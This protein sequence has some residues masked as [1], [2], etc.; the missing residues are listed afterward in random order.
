MTYIAPRHSCD[1]WRVLIR[2]K[3]DYCMSALAGEL[4]AHTDPRPGIVSG[5]D[6][7]SGV[8]LRARQTT[9]RLAESG[10]EH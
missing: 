7:R 10:L 8:A 2:A 6:N 3:A 4:G 9:T 5:L 1:K